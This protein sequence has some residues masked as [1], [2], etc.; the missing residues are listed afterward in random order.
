MYTFFQ[1]YISGGGR[2]STKCYIV[3]W[4]ALCQGYFQ[5]R[6]D[7]RLAFLCE[8]SSTPKKLIYA[9]ATEHPVIPIGLPR[10]W[11]DI[12]A[13]TV[14]TRRAHAAKVSCFQAC[15]GLGRMDRFFVFFWRGLR[16]RKRE[17]VALLRL[18]PPQ[19]G[20]SL[21]NLFATEMA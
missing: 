9:C 11:G 16:F 13:S 18:Q 1:I 6:S 7:A 14:L 17:P 8:N 2:F 10:G 20:E 19:V 21:G 3:L 5:H 4:V 12:F 15:R